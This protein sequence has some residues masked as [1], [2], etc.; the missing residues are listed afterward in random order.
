MGALLC[1]F[2]VVARAADDNFL[3]MRE[4]FIQ[5]FAQGKHLRLALIFDQCKHIHREGGLHLRLREQAVQNDLR[6]RLA[7]QL[8]HDAHTVAV[9]LVANVGNTLQTLLV[10]LIRHVF[11]E[12]PLVDLIGNLGDDDPLAVLPELL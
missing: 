10:D 9:G 5:N 3:L 7:L 2:E 8:D 12:H 1:F 4:V 11:D 6:V